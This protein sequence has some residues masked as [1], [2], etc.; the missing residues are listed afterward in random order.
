MQENIPNKS[1]SPTDLQYQGSSVI[2]IN[3]KNIE[4]N[5]IVKVQSKQPLH[6]SGE[7]LQPGVIEVIVKDGYLQRAKL[8]SHAAKGSLKNGSLY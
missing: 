6:G 1:Y 5:Q 4:D 3:K 7:S 2:N 8:L